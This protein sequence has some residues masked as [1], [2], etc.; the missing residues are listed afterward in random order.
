MIH[1]KPGDKVLD[2]II[3]AW[4]TIKL[5][6]GKVVHMTDNGYLGI[7]ECSEVKVSRDT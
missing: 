7:H 3:F 6:E 4:R 1:L 2:P 5:I